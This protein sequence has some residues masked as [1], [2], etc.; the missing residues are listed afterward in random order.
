MNEALVATPLDPSV[1][2]R[3]YCLVDGIEIRE[4]I[5][6]VWDYSA[7]KKYISHSEIEELQKTRYWLCVS[8]CGDSLTALPDDVLFEKVLHGLLA[9]QIICPVGAQRALLGFVRTSTGYINISARHSKQLGV[10]KIARLFEWREEC[11]VDD[12][13]STYTMIRQAFDVSIVRLQN[14][15]YLFEHG[16]QLSHV[17]LSTMFFVMALDMLVMAG[18]GRKFIERLGGFLGHTS[19]VFPRTLDAKLQPALKVQD[20]LGDLYRLRN[21]L[22]HGLEVPNDPYRKLYRM[23]L[24]GPSEVAAN[25]DE[26][27][28]AEIMLECSL[29]LLTHSCP[30]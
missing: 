24:E 11:I 22:A 18:E 5:Q 9:L 27:Y 30:N 25:V 1:V 26:Y 14:P 13:S 4:N 28:Y 29:F 6:I 17:Y 16:M 21:I 3:P 7:I 19:Y 12:F 8:R 23:R 20:V 15:L 10:S 2:T